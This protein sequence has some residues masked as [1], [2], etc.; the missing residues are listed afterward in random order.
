MRPPRARGPLCD[1]VLRH[2]CD[3]RINRPVTLVEVLAALVLA[4]HAPRQEALTARR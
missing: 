3:R 1:S 2:R 4:D